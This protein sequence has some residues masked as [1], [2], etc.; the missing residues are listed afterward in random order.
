[1]NRRL[2]LLLATHVLTLAVGFG[3]GVYLLPILT[4]PDGPS[5]ALVAEAMGNSDYSARFERTLRGSD[6][7][8]WADGAVSV[9]AAQIAFDG[10]MAPGPDYKV[11]LTNEFVDTRGDF[12]RIKQDAQLIGDVKTFERFLLDVPD[13][14]DV[15]AYTTVV[16]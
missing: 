3:T 8:H 6:P 9:S 7:V 10:R 11:Y 5:A 2:T 1:M 4:A 16:V 15:N 14:V 13:S 12:L